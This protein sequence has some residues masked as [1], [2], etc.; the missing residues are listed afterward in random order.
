MTLKEEFDGILGALNLPI[1]ED[2][3]KK[4]IKEYF[5]VNYADERPSLRGDDEDLRD[6]V[7]IQVHYYYKDSPSTTKKAIRK[8]LRQAGYSIIN[9]EQFYEDATEYTHVVV[10]AW[11]EYENTD[12][13]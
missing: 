13:E 11:K 2:H 8:L 5:I 4:G 12:M 7:I 1:A 6:E 3:Y 10:E 9:T